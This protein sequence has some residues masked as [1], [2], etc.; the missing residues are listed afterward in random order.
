MSPPASDNDLPAR[1]R[2]S[3]ETAASDLKK[4]LETTFLTPPT[5]F[6]AEWLNRL[7]RRWDEQVDYTD[8][9]QLAPTQSRTVTRFIREGLEGRVTGYKEVTVP[10]SGATAKDSTSMLRRPANRADFVRGAAGYF[11]FAPGGLDGVDAIQA[12]EDEVQLVESQGAKKVN[13][14]DRII[15]FGGG[16]GLLEIPPGFT[17]GMSFEKLEKDTDDTVKSTLR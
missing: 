10:A 6:S 3:R 15:K 12:Y 2:Q 14:L 1:M 5:T 7:Q 9:C 8:I 17:R 11:P 13:G 16:D 4:N